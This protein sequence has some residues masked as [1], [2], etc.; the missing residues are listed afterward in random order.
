MSL[1]KIGEI[2]IE[3]IPEL[4]REDLF[5]S[6]LP[7]ASELIEAVKGTIYIDPEHPANKTAK[8]LHSKGGKIYYSY[9]AIDYYGLAKVKNAFKYYDYFR[10]AKGMDTVLQM[11]VVS[12]IANSIFDLD[13]I[14]NEVNQE[15]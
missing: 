14:N 3:D 13:R 1:K 5:K 4:K 9:E 2:G 8:M 7:L 12:W 11:G 10:K 6:N 15:E